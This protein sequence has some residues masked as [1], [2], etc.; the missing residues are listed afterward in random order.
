MR[1]PFRFTWLV[2]TSLL[3]LAPPVLA[4]QASGIA[5]IVR[6]TS[7]AVLPGVTVEATSPA[8]IEKLRTAVTDGEGR[9][10]IVDLRPGPYV[11]TFTLTGFTSVRREG[12][13]LPGG[14]TAVVN[15]DMRVG[16]LQETITVTGESPIVDVQ[17]VR[18]QT[19]VSDELLAALPSATRTWGTL[20]TLTP[21][22]NYASGLTSFTGTGGVYAENNPQRS[23]FGVI[24][25]FHGK[26]GAQ[27]EYDGMGT[28]YPASTGGMGYVSNA[29][30]AEE[31]RVQTGGISAESKTSGMSFDMIPKEGGNTFS[32]LLYGHD[33]SSALQGG[34]LNDSL[35]ARG[36]TTGPQ[37]DF[38][39]D[40]AA[41]LGGRVVRDKL[42]FFTTHRRTASKNQIPGLFYNRTQSTPFY[43]PD[44]SRPGFTDDWFRSD[45]LRLTWQA[46]ARNKINVFADNQRNCAC[47]TFQPNQAV[48]S[49]QTFDFHP[50]GLYQ[51]S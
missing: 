12:I 2:F 26:T 50:Q 40:V 45:A 48:E 33:T 32:G 1:M 30:T 16:G 6:D 7:G 23:S 39:Y 28:N 47:R 22:L 36:L 41:S 24:S 3:L 27:T 19:S 17:A 35:R 38:S 49:M 37:V 11:V 31:M 43:T 14:F 51:F 13:N 44:P 10:S 25:S 29:Y 5:G 42:W 20:A 21:G 9:Y 15:A 4:Q 8:L 34:N 18:Q 46:S